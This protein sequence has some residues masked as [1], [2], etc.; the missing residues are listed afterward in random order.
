MFPYESRDYCVFVSWYLQPVSVDP[1]AY[2]VWGLASREKFLAACL[3]PGGR[4]I[5]TSRWLC[6]TFRG[7]QVGQSLTNIWCSGETE[8]NTEH[9]SPLTFDTTSLFIRWREHFEGR[10]SV[11]EIR[12]K[13][14][15]HQLSPASPTDGTQ[16]YHYYTLALVILVFV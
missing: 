2:L 5:I 7:K 16:K 6:T 10:L 11:N 9:M 12:F 14:W 15:I 3:G 8:Q 13:W 1:L 4:H